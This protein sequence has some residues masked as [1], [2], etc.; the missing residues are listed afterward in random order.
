[1][2]SEEDLS[3][4]S[5]ATATAAVVVDAQRRLNDEAIRR[6]EDVIGCASVRDSRSLGMMIRDG[7]W[8]GGSDEFV[9]SKEGK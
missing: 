3:I 5:A 8:V 2:K 1:M 4:A 7:R 9:S 6:K